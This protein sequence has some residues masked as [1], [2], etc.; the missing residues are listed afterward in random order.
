MAFTYPPGHK[1]RKDLLAQIRSSGT[2]EYNGNRLYNGGQLKVARRA[3]AGMASRD[4]SD[5]RICPNC[6][7]YMCKTK[8]HEHYR[9]CTA[10]AAVPVVENDRRLHIS[11]KLL[12]GDVHSCASEI[13]RSRVFP[14]LRDDDCTM[15]IRFDEVAISYGNNMCER[16]ASSPHHDQMIRANLRYLGNFLLAARSINDGVTDLAS[17]FSPPMKDAVVLAIYKIAGFDMES[18]MFKSAGAAKTLVGLVKSATE[19]YKCICIKKEDSIGYERAQKF[20]T[21]FKTSSGRAISRVSQENRIKNLR[22]KV[23]GTKYCA[24]IRNYT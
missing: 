9:R 22:Q 11:S 20:I 19:A 23:S 10:V 18:G 1:I 14:V 7:R 24:I 4:A 15:A 5:F 21:L 13:L 8:L 17:L 16:Y 12:I 3:P 6:K 2:L